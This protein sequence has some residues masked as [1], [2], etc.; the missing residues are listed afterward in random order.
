MRVGI[1]LMAWTD[2]I[3][4][5]ELRLFTWFKELGYDGVE[6]PLLAL[7]R[8]DVPSI[9]SALAASG[10]SCTASTALPPGATLLQSEGSAAA[11]DFLR[12]CVQIAGQLGAEVLCGPLYAPV[13]QRDHPPTGGERTA[14]VHALQDLAPFAEAHGVLLAVEPINRFETAFLNTI[15]DATDLAQRIGHPFVGILADT[16]HMNIEEK[17][18]AVSLATVGALLKH[19]HFSEN[20]R[21][22]IGSGHVPWSRV[23]QALRGRRYDGWVV[24]E[25]FAGHLPQLAAAT[26]IWRPLVESPER[27][28]EESLRAFRSW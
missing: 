6:I 18:P 9:R 12:R 7:E 21:G 19:V 3:G 25:T 27:Y 15:E 28:A 11:L 5:H 8:M 4:P 17:D 10:L 20:D 13:G 24:F 23:M 22:V 14:C 26:A 1:N 16:F 2:T